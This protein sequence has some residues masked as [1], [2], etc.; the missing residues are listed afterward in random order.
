MKIED[1]EKMNYSELVALVKE[2]NR[3]SGRIKTIQNVAVNAF[4]T[5]EKFKKTKFI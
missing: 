5:K 4:I 2:R 1:I 3:P